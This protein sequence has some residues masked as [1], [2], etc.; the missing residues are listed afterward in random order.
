MLFKNKLLSTFSVLFLALFMFSCTDNGPVGPD[1][2]DLDFRQVTY[3]LDAISNDGE[4]PN[5]VNATATFQELNDNQ[6]LVTLELENGSTASGLTHTA[7]IHKN[8]VETGGDIAY[9]LGPIDGLDGSPGKSEYVVDVSFDEL[10][11]FDG[12]INIHESNSNLGAILGQGNIGS[13]SDAEIVESELTPIE[14]PQ[15]KEYT[16]DASQNGGLLPDG[17]EAVATFQEL[18]SGQTLVKLELVNGSTETE[19]SHTAHIHFNN[20]VE[21]GD[22]AYFLG[23]IDGLSGSAGISYAVVN[24]S[25]DFLTDFDGYINIHESNSN[26]GAIVSQGNIGANEGLTTLRSASFTLD[27][28]PNSGAVASG[29][30]ATATFW[31]L[32]DEQTVVTL[33]LDDST[34]ASVVHTSHIHFN[35]AEEG[36]DIAYFLTPIDGSDPDATSARIINE[37]FDTLIEFDGYINIHESVENIGTI[38]TQGN[39]GANAD[40]QLDL[41]LDVVDNPRDIVYDLGAVSNSGEFFPNGVNAKATFLEV[42]SELTIVTLDLDTNG[43]TGVSKSHPAHIHENSVEQGGGIAFYLGAIDAMDPDSRSSMLIGES[44]DDLT[45]FNGY[46]NIHESLTTLDVILS[47]GNIGSNAGSGGNGNGSGY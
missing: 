45:S 32:N 31:E 18:T 7:H 33:T 17:A 47:Q 4:I 39:I 26:L 24:E 36:G 44:Y 38:V 25:F 21:G 6:T 5:G 2:P 20:V 11:D 16:L 15:I 23:P 19:L 9:F 46:I 30:G 34:G 41:G 40:V 27:A 13:N 43:A 29:V 28:N 37:S 10:I 3:S 8:D 12:Y 22:I 42:T 35:S 14:N 1:G